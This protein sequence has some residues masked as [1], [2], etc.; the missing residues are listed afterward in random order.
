MKNIIVIIV[1]LLALVSVG[2]FIMTTKR[3][4][5]SFAGM[6]GQEPKSEGK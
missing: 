2:L 6:H 5:E 4:S 1:I 3:L